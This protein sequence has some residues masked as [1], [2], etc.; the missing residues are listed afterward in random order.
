MFGKNKKKTKKT[1]TWGMSYDKNLDF[2]LLL[3]FF[4]LFIF[5]IL[6]Q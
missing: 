3:D 2:H 1:I 4:Y 6:L 5:Y